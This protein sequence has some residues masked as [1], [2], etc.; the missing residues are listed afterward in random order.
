MV[1]FLPLM[2][3]TSECRGPACE[4]AW[5]ASILH[6][7]TA[8]GL[9]SAA[10][11]DDLPFQVLGALEDGAH[12]SVAANDDRIVVGM[13]ER[14][15]VVWFDAITARADVEDL[16]LGR[17]E[18]L[19]EAFGS[20]VAF[21]DTDGDGRDELW[22]GA[23]D[24]DDG[25]GAVYGY[26]L[27]ELD[28]DAFT[29][30]RTGN[31]PDDGVGTTLHAC[32][33]L[34]GD[35]RD[36]VLTTAPRLADVGGEPIARLAGAVIRLAPGLSEG[37]VPLDSD[38]AWWGDE[39]GAGVGWSVDCHNDVTAD[40]RTDVVI[41]SPFAGTDDNGLVFVRPG[42]TELQGGP[43]MRTDPW[44]LIPPDDGP[45]RFGA[46]VGTAGSTVVVGAPH[47]SSGGG[48]VYVYDEPSQFPGLAQPTVR[49]DNPTDQPDHFGSH[50]AL[51]D[52]DGDGLSDLVVGAPDRRQVDTVNDA[53]TEY[54]VGA[55]WLWTG[56]DRATWTSRA[57]DAIGT[58][59]FQ[60]VGRSPVFAD[61]DGDGAHDLLL[62]VRA[63][64]PARG[65]TP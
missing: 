35:G 41:G 54:D 20:A 45:L 46:A 37:A 23:P 17:L 21:V 13:P 9:G 8:D 61:L 3:C 64:E 47:A 59:A 53:R 60:R 44:T 63:P 49:L 39:A 40:G 7:V 12:W 28:A 50:L 14:G 31:T 38:T 4:Q 18:R 15:A 36:E 30:R 34:D 58:H 33:D 43:L 1:L 32:R 19:D 5:P 51:G 25:R 26:E 48:R 11:L 42:G 2:G 16:T 6:R 56:S 62:P 57:P 24:A 55:L 10:D 52:L 29:T 27:G 65:A 22:V